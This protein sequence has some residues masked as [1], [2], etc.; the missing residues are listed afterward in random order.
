MVMIIGSL[1]DF[2]WISVIVGVDWMLLKDETGWIQGNWKQHQNL[3]WEEIEKE[4]K[5]IDIEIKIVYFWICV[6][7]FHLLFD[8]LLYGDSSIFK[9]STNQTVLLLSCFWAQW[10]L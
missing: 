9:Q 4:K 8:S 6:H 5:E 1:F 3:W 7:S 2:R 10:I